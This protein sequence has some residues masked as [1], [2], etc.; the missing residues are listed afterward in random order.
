MHKQEAYSPC[1]NAVSIKANDRTNVVVNGWLATP[2]IS[3]EVPRDY[4]S[5]TTL[6]LPDC[7]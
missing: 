5:T 7:T 3:A 2:S 4:P 6:Q 1:L